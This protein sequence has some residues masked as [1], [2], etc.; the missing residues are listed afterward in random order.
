MAP[1]LVA[2]GDELEAAAARAL[3]RRRARRQ[4][5]LNAAASLMI[6]VPFAIGVATTDLSQSPV[7]TG[8]SIGDAAPARTAPPAT[9]GYSP[10]VS[11]VPDERIAYLR[12]ARTPDLLIMP[13]VLRPALR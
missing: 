4:S 5:I 13:T 3:G 1:D 11:H 10:H 12:E 8:A 7:A 2:L 9:M 6:A